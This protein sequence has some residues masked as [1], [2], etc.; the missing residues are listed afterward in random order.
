MT[1]VARRRALGERRPAL[2][3]VT[4]RRLCGEGR[5]VDRVEAALRGGVSAVQ[6]REKDLDGRPL[7]ELAAALLP[8]CRRFGAPLLINGRI[9]IA[10][11]AD[12][13]GVHL[14]EDSFSPAEART[15][16]GAE[17]I[18]GVSSH[19]P[20]DVAAAAEAGAD[21]AVFGPIFAT[22][23]KAAYGAPQGLEQLRRAVAAAN[24]PVVAIGGI[25]PERAPAVLATGVAGIA[26]IAA[27]LSP[28]DGESAA[29]AFT[30]S[31]GLRQEARRRQEV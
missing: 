31:P 1:A 16:L 6:L 13:D 28:A 25:T 17:K 12:A 29:R 27:L 7:L 20:E 30:S 2:Y 15:L 21:Y 14:P 4:D 24:I 26:A 8:I 18:V 11:A 9:D 19:R 3:L 23:A 22:P 10:L 5:I